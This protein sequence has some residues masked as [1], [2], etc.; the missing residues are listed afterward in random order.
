MKL[1]EMTRMAFENLWKTRLRTGLTV[2]GVV[3]GIGA[4]VSMVSFGTGM[5]KNITETFLQNDLFTSMQVLP[6]KIDL[7]EAMRGNPRAMMEPRAGKDSVALDQAAL[8]K[9]RAVPEVEIAFPEIRFPVKVRF[10]GREA[11]TNLRAMPAAMGKYKPLN[12]L[13]SGLFYSSDTQKVAIIS[14]RLLRDLKIR[15]I[16]PADP[17]KTT[18]ED[19]L[20]GFRSVNMDSLVGKDIELVTSVL[21]LAG[22][23]RNPPAAAGPAGSPKLPFSDRTAH[24]RAAGIAKQTSGFDQG[25]FESGLIVPMKS[26]ESLP[27][28]NFSSVWDILSRKSDSGGF[29]SLYVRVKKMGDL[30][31][32][33]KSIEDMGF[34][35]V[36]IADQLEDFKKGFLIFD[37][38]LG[39]VG[40]IALIVAA[41]GII[42]TM[43]MSILERTREIGIMKAV[44]GGENDIRGIFFVEAGVIG[45]VGGIFGLGLG[46]LVTRIA[47]VIAN[48]V[49]AKQGGPSM[50]FFYIPPWLILGA[51]AF[52]V[53]VSLLAGLY[54]AMRASRVNPVEALRHD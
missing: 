21:D 5:Q 24:F 28:F 6:R 44:G 20:K 13:A 29:S 17:K 38:L 53:C 25:F 8:E 27:R 22:M 51:M 3:I 34:G 15:L 37:T 9:I 35:V 45:F 1:D 32:V 19:T 11:T 12:K 43:V 47:N 52:S 40:T 42:N 41:L 36:S 4:L 7:D 30:A 23:M 14:P 10:L 18:V 48:V 2:L 33:K 26:A 39:A 31:A 54:P 46:W 50:D 16:D 49:M